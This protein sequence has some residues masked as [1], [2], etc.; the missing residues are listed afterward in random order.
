M[1]DFTYYNNKFAVSASW[2]IENIVSYDT[3]KYHTRKG[4]FKKLRRGGGAGNVALIEYDSIRPEKYKYLIQDVL[5]MDPYE[6]IRRNEFMSLII[7]DKKAYEFFAAELRFDK[8]ADKKLPVY[9]ANAEVLNAVIRRYNSRRAMR[10]KL[11]GTTK[12]IWQ[13][14]SREVN[15]VDKKQ[16]PHSLPQ[17]KDALRKKA[18]QYQKHGYVTLLH[19][20]RHNDHSKKRNEKLDYLIINIY[21]MQNKPYAE[22]VHQMY[23][24]FLSGSIALVDRVTGEVFD[25]TDP[26]YVE[27][28]A[29]TVWNIVT[30]PKYEALI[31][32]MRD[33]GHTYSQL[34]RPHHHRHAPKYSLSKITLDDRDIMH[35]KSNDKVAVKCYYVFDDVS[36]A[37]IGRAYN[38]KKNDVL[39]IDS[40]KDMFLFLR[41]NGIG[42]P[43]QA[44]VENHL[45][46]DFEN[47]LMTVFPFVRW[48]NPANSQEKYAE[49]LIGAKKYGPEK[50]NNVGVGRH[51]SRR[52]TNRITQ[53]KIFDE[54]NN[55]FKERLAP[56]EV[57]VANDK[58]EIDQ[59]NNELH[60][61][62]D[63]YPGKTRMQVFMDNL[64]P[65]LP[66]LPEYL[67]A[68]YIG[69]RVVT[70][71]RRNSYVRANNEKF[72]ITD[73]G[74]LDQLAPNDKNVEVYYIPD[75][76]GKVDKVYIYQNNRFIGE[77]V[78]IATYNRANAEWTDADHANYTKQAAYLA[79]FDKRIKEQKEKATRVTV[80]PNEPEISDNEP[81]IIDTITEDEPAPVPAYQVET[82]YGNMAVND[83]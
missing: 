61:N 24:Q 67:F 39:F 73:F 16:Y 10:R 50:R 52:A 31:A 1:K 81:V 46:R 2:L 3:Y 72:M 83:L 36:G 26:A 5:G 48:T 76:S 80:I 58:A 13:T 49:R 74:I 17:S 14:L 79:Q 60:P 15:S 9:V 34:H 29:A 44:E 75:E 6:Y 22:W 37:V 8:N 56:F 18:K 55:N 63:K 64:N 62:Q 27:I 68:K 77:A 23:E 70:S 71:I 59:Y 35:T 54:D 38:K 11:G 42:L 51:Y 57:I 12:D 7:P 25:H 41:R 45:V 33:G 78:Q 82:D 28:S 32:K 21:V 40:I 4:N 47:T 53:Q 69:Y 20:N 43:L 19:G 30:S 65:D 66:E